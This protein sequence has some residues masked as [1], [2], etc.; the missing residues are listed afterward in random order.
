MWFHTKMWSQNPVKEI[1]TRINER[2][3]NPKLAK[4]CYISL[5]FYQISSILYKVSINLFI[6]QTKHI[7]RCNPFSFIIINVLL[8]LF[9]FVFTFFL[10]QIAGHPW[11]NPDTIWTY[12]TLLVP[13]A[14]LEIIF[15]FIILIC[16]C[17]RQ[18]Q[19]W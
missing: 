17:N 12:I 8:S 19:I 5:F 4:S 14:N 16:K 11:Y 18:N 9:D 15:T 2:K 7:Y 10:F 6:F 13:R 1:T 3:T